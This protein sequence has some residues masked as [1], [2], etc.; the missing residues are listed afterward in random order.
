MHKYRAQREQLE[1]LAL[2][3]QA[4]AQARK[5]DTE[6]QEAQAWLARWTAGRRQGQ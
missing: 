6:A 2:Q 3:R 4:T 1:A 5:A